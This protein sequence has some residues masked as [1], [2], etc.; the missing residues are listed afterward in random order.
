MILHEKKFGRFVFST[1]FVIISYQKVLF[2]LTARFESLALDPGQEEH[3][4]DSSSED[5]EW[6]ESTTV[7]E[8]RPKQRLQ[9]QLLCAKIL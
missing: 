1:E 5:G 9:R 8:M 6:Y 4:G 2:W 7:I 3:D